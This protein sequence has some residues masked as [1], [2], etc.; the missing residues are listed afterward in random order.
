MRLRHK[1]GAED[2]VF[3]SIY[4][5]NM[6]KNSENLNL[7]NYFDLKRPLYLELGMGKGKFICEMAKINPDINFIGVEKYATVV[8]KAI[9]NYKKIYLGIEKS[10]EIPNTISQSNN[11]KFLCEDVNNL[12]KYFH[13]KSIDKIFLNFSD[14]WPKK[15]HEERRLTHHGFLSLYEKILK[16]NGCIEFKTDNIDLFDFSLEELKFSS[17]KLIY[18]TH[19]LHADK[20]LSI[21]NI[22]TE[23]EH[24]FKA[25][26]NP[27]C[28]Y[29]ICKK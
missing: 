13:E 1:K 5:I 9:D 7:A 19:D 17:F 29:K 22:E 8:L 28:K 3:K 14:P 21:G 16:D 23:Y 18:E 15:R 27:I 12:P 11:L 26:G 2:L 20:E 6:S 4:C 24:K 25:L 10:D